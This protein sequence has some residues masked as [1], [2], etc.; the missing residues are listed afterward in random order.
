MRRLNLFR[1][2]C[3]IFLGLSLVVAAGLA[4]D[5]FDIVVGP[6]MMAQIEKTYGPEARKRV[7]MWLKL[8][9]T[10]ANVPEADKLNYVNLF[11]NQVQFVD[12]IIHWHKA[13]YWAT[14]VETLA[15]NGG[16]CEDFAIAKYMSLKAMGV[17]EEKLR[18]TYVKALKLNQAHMV[19]TYLATPTSEPLVLDNLDPAIKPASQRPDLLPIYS[20]NGSGL[21]MAKARGAGERV[22]GSDQVGLWSDLL[23]R[24]KN[25]ETGS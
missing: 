8:L 24:M 3:A 13:D 19:L 7:E 15:S 2:G 5:H 20:F 1:K 25:I 12:D 16:D 4:A 17:P 10:E 23:N 9:K 14:P 6:E 18:M 11:V 21:F 22:G